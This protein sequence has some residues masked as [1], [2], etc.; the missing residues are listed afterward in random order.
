MNKN[1]VNILSTIIF[2]FLLMSGV[3]AR[4]TY[5]WELGPKYNEENYSENEVF[6]YVHEGIAASIVKTDVYGNNQDKNIQIKVGIKNANIYSKSSITIEALEHDKFGVMG[7]LEKEIE[8]SPSEYKEVVFNYYY[9][10]AKGID[11]NKYKDVRILPT[12]TPKEGNEDENI[13]Q[14]SDDYISTK[15]IIEESGTTNTS[16]T[17]KIG[18]IEVSS[19]L[20]LIIALIIVVISIIFL[21]LI[22]KYIHVNRGLFVFVVMILLSLILNITSTIAYDFQSFEFD[23]KYTHVYACTA[24]HVSIPY[25]FKFNIS[26]VFDGE[27]PNLSRDTDSDGDGLNDLYEMY[28]ITDVNNSD[29][30]GDGIPDGIEIY[31]IDTDPLKPDTNDD[32]TSD[33]NDDYDKDKFVNI[34]EVKHGTSLINDDTDYDKLT[35]YDEVK[36][37]KTNPL[38]KDTDN[39][40][41]SDYE[42][43][44]ICR[45]LNI[46][47]TSDIDK[48]T[49]LEQKLSKDS[50]DE[51]FYKN[52]TIDFEVSGN[53]YGLIDEHVK[54]KSK[55]NVVIDNVDYIIESPLLIESD[56]D[57]E[58]LTVAFDLKNYSERINGIK[59]AT[60][61]EG[62]L[63]F[64][65]TYKEDSII[66]VNVKDGYIMLID[67]IKLVGSIINYNEDNYK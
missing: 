58:I 61:E 34:E 23:K 12:I 19:N 11:R 52:N 67:G 1:F 29:T 4:T 56:Y 47:Y 27:K 53:L 31:Y 20:M 46:D 51:A 36:I 40:G 44:Q 9:K 21:V 43:V 25:T 37:Y 6:E 60:L 28:F 3:F 7:K 64:L 55:T 26:Y 63:K 59:I 66:S 54:I 42:E 18:N 41:I 39:D 49:K 65:E 57:N 33:G 35:D 38:E 13:L 24:Y 62:K 30:D 17:I 32:G 15:S 14:D 2:I 50:M 8:L 5:Y 22:I 16:N 48:N 45:I 10:D